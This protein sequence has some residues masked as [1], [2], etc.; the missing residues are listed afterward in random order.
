MLPARSGYS[1]AVESLGLGGDALAQ[2]VGDETEEERKKR[3]KQVQERALMGET[4]SLATLAL[5][6]GAGGPAF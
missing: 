4:G 3:I 6:G 5:F 1:P 2:Q